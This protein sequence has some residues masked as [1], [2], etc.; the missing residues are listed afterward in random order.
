[1]V[2]V[3]GILLA[4]AVVLAAVYFVNL[5]QPIPRPISIPTEVRSAF[6]NWREI[7]NVK[8]ATPAEQNHRLRIFHLNFLKI[9][10]TKTDS[11]TLGLNQFA[12]LSEPEFVAKYTGYRAQSK[13][14]KASNSVHQ[15]TLG[16]QPTNVDWRQQGAVNPVKNQ[17]QCGSCWAFS[18][19]AAFESASKI[20]GFALYSLSEQQLVDCSGPEG[21]QG[22]NGGLMDQAFEYIQKFGGLET[23]T[24]YPYKAV[25]GK[26]V[27]NTSK[28]TPPKVVSWTDVTKNKCADLLTAIAQ[29]PVSV[30]I[31]ANAIQFYVKG[32]FSSKFCGTGLNHGVT[33]IGYGHDT[34]SNKDYWLVR[35]SWG[36]TW[37]EGGYILMDRAIQPT[38]GI[39]GIC[40]DASYPNVSKP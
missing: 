29:Q 24:S 28:L 20:G 35:N 13:K 33:A 15:N 17:G 21:N 19:V 37:G 31:A 39:C 30:A 11:Y 27:A 36:S 5:P 1:M 25:D 40:M 8:F 34:S 3:T 26:C 18:A 10:G 7:Y 2:K 22:C 23:E 32:V 4:S 12:H 9:K 6:L 38:N 14:L 16:Q